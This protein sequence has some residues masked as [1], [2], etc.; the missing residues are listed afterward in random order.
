MSN[1]PPAATIPMALPQVDQKW[2]RG[3]RRGGQQQ[4]VCIVI[5]YTQ[6]IPV[7]NAGNRQPMQ[8]SA[9]LIGNL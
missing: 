4:L 9:L 7:I 6:I 1:K 3:Q 8:P 5:T 2:Q